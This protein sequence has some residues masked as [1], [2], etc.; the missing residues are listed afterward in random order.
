MA[1]KRQHQVETEEG[2][3][4]CVVG[5][6]WGGGEIDARPGEPVSANEN[7]N[8]PRWSLEMRI[9]SKIHPARFELINVCHFAPSGVK[10]R[11]LCWPM[12]AARGSAG[13]R[14]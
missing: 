9:V 5:A 13:A 6:Q 10:D 12:A 11:L 2:Q 1:W 3:R 4:S 8:N 7:T 14:A